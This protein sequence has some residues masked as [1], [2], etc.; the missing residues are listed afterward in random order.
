MKDKTPHPD[1]HGSDYPRTSVSRKFSRIDKHIDLPGSSD[2]PRA[3]ISHKP[4]HSERSNARTDVR[5]Q[6]EKDLQREIKQ[7]LRG[8]S[9]K[10]IPELL[11]E[12]EVISA[13]D[14]LVECGI[15]FLHKERTLCEKTLEYIIKRGPLQFNEYA[16]A[17]GIAH[18]DK[19]GK[20][21]R[22]TMAQMG[23]PDV[24]ESE[25]IEL[26]DWTCMFLAVMS[27]RSGNYDDTLRMLDTTANY[28]LVL[29]PARFAFIMLLK[30]KSFLEIRQAEE[31]LRILRMRQSQE[32]ALSQIGDMNLGREEKDGRSSST[33]RH[34]SRIE[35][36]DSPPATPLKRGSIL[37][38]EEGDSLAAVHA[39]HDLHILLMFD[40]S[41]DDAKNLFKDC[42]MDGSKRPPTLKEFVKKTS[43][44]N[45][46]DH[47]ID[48][49]MPNVDELTRQM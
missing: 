11:V 20:Q 45:V 22:S 39:C 9:W 49:W 24:L 18:L 15:Q 41:E 29:K 30:A 28:Q 6:K 3:S 48:N 14:V 8:D 16:F 40:K 26:K 13:R 33:T 21:R 10:M 38:E 12:W 25:W 47:L 32:E 4:P 2:S 43:V 1:L 42:K 27:F 37:V 23:L 46:G 35:D 17:S 44:R 31:A 19:E 5:S 7:V 36:S 34:H